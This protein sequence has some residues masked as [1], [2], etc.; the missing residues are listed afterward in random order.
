MSMKKSKN[1]KY[2]ITFFEEK[3]LPHKDFDMGRYI[4]CT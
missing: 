4:P 3:D 1:A 2:L